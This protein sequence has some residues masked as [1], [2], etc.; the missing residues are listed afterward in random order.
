MM[1]GASGQTSSSRSLE[2]IFI[3]HA[4]EDKDFV[5]TLVE[6]L[7]QKGLDAWHQQDLA[8]GGNYMSEIDARLDSCKAGIVVWSRS[9]VTSEYV[10]AEANRLRERE[11]LVP[12]YIEECKPPIV[13]GLIQGIKCRD[14]RSLTGEE[15]LALCEA[16]GKLLLLG[17]RAEVLANAN[18]V[19]KTMIRSKLA[20]SLSMIH[21]QQLSIGFVLGVLFGYSVFQWFQSASKA[22]LDGFVQSAG[23]VPP[24]NEILTL[25][26]KFPE[27]E[28]PIDFALK[29][30]PQNNGWAKVIVEYWQQHYGAQKRF[31]MMYC[32][33]LNKMVTLLYIRRFLS[34]SS[35]GKIDYLKQQN[36][37]TPQG[38]GR[39]VAAQTMIADPTHGL[40][41]YLKSYRCLGDEVSWP[42]IVEVQMSEPDP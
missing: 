9:S 29:H 36:Y 38:P 31:A 13:F 6:Y 41:E 23:M 42:L 1:S 28:K 37:K 15:V 18:N 10:K 30:I 25:G 5:R 26:S 27:S 21:I 3:S 4:T 19:R 16:I 34:S 12:L 2:A 24:A 14:R 32:Q 17:S 22:D 11:C 8:V 35:S 39:D 7:R 20:R 33:T 40:P